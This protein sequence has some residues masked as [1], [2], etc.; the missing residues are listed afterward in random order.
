MRERPSLLLGALALVAIGAVIFFLVL[1]RPGETA[2]PSPSPSPAASPSPSPRPSPT[3]PLNQELL[4]RRLTV[5]VIGL[6]LNQAREDD[7]FAPNT[8]TLILASVSADQAEVTLISLPRDTVDIPLPDGG[9]WDRKVNA[10]YTERGVEA[11]VGAM[12]ELFDVPIDHYAA[13]DMDD[14]EAL[15]AA[16]DGVTVEVAEPLRD[17]ALD[18][19]LEAGRQTLDAET[20]LDYVRTRVDTD[21]GRIARQQ[22]VLPALLEELVDPSTEVDLAALLEALDSLRTD[23]PLDEL[24]TLMEIARR[25]QDAQVTREVLS[26]PRFITFEGIAAGRGYILVP[27]VEAIRAV[28]RQLI[29][30]EPAG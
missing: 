9:I 13:V 28:A 6:D 7:G 20:A 22:Q 30:D 12:E 17:A 21:Y 25:A 11:L 16:V 5:L 2:G 26:P 19:D 18:L 15:V 8:D 24:P 10:I 4:S 1:G 3:P 27:D 14:F 29:G 23:L